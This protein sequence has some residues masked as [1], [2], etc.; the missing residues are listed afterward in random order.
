VTLSVGIVASLFTAMF[1]SRLIFDYFLDR[2]P[3]KRLSI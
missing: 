3:V 2:R 1:V